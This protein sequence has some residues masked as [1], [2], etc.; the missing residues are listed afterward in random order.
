MDHP[1]NPR[2]HFLHVV[3]QVG[4]GVYLGLLL[5]IQQNLVSK[6]QRLVFLHHFLVFKAMFV[7]L[8]DHVS[9]LLLLLPLLCY[10]CLDLVLQGSYRLLPRLVQD[11]IVF[12]LI[13]WVLNLLDLVFYVSLQLL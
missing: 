9:T 2:L 11:D 7:K 6:L 5:L 3:V 8:L 13:I 4:L 1:L 10:R 12:G